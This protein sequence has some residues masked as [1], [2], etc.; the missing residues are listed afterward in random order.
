MYQAIKSMGV[1]VSHMTGLIAHFWTCVNKVR[2]IDGPS[3]LA[4]N[5]GLR[6]RLSRTNSFANY[7]GNFAHNFG[8]E[9]HGRATIFE[10]AQSV[11]DVIISVNEDTLPSYMYMLSR[12]ACPSRYRSCCLD[13]TFLLVFTWVSPYNRNEVSFGGKLVHL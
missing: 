2:G 1:E 12:T 6:N 7:V 5:L 3:R 4:I 9:S 8:I 11:K 10:N 13:D